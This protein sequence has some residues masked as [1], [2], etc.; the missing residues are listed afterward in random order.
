MRPVIAVR[1]Q[2]RWACSNEAGAF[3]AA[4]SRVPVLVVVLGLQ[5]GY[6]QGGHV[7]SRL[8]RSMLPLATEIAV[9]L[10]TRW[11]CSI[12]AGASNAAISNWDRSQVTNKVGMVK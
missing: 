3:N 6:K 8:V 4:V 1:L 7:Q 9:R 12:E 10:Q 11:A 5:S 2:T